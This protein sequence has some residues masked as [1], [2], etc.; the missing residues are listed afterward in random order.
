MF[1]S[2]STTCSSCG[3]TDSTISAGASSHDWTEKCQ[4]YLA[5]GLAPSTHQV[6][7]SAQRQFLEFCNQDIPSDLSHPLLPASKQTLMRFSAHLADRLHHSSVKV[8]L[9]AVRSLHIDYGYPDPLSNC[10]QLQHL[11]NAV[12][13]NLTE[14]TTRSTSLTSAVSGCYVCACARIPRA[15]APQRMVSFGWRFFVSV[16]S[17]SV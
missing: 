15:L 6:Y 11:L 13:C 9:S 12:K 5:N 1:P 8:Y 2:F 7:G 17:I 4:F 10:L 14:L 16:S 3:H